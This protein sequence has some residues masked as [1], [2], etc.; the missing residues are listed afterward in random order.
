[1]PKGAKMPGAKTLKGVK[2]EVAS[3]LKPKNGKA[4]D[5]SISVAGKLKAAAFE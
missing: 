4:S 5:A 1:M 3:S 2:E